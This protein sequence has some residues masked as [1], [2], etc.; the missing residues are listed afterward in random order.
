MADMNTTKSKEMVS[1]M[2]YNGMFFLVTWIPVSIIAFAFHE[3]YPGYGAITWAYMYMVI[4]GISIAAGCVMWFI[5]NENDNTSLA[6]ITTTFAYTYIGGNTVLGLHWL[7]S[8][9]DIS[10]CFKASWIAGTF[11]LTMSVFGDH[12]A[13]CESREL[14]VAQFVCNTIIVAYAF[15]RIVMFSNN[16]ESIA[17]ESKEKF[18]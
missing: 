18:E 16:I 6:V 5:A 15:Y 3:L 10:A 17:S 9:L 7:R 1:W 14:V 4:G 11:P 13:I 8:L 2:L 12:T